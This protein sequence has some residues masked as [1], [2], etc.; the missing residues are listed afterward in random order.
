MFR[1][2]DLINNNK[3]RIPS[4]LADTIIVLVAIRCNEGSLVTCLTLT[5]RKC[6]VGD[7]QALR[8]LRSLSKDKDVMKFPKWLMRADQPALPIVIIILLSII[9]HGLTPSSFYLVLL[10][11]DWP[12]IPNSCT[13][14][15]ADLPVKS[16][17]RTLV[18]SRIVIHYRIDA[19]AGLISVIEKRIFQHTVVL[20]VI[21]R[22]VERASF[23][24]LSNN[25]SSLETGWSS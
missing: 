25:G 7:Q 1:K 16:M 19:S 22:L 11:M 3:A 2:E 10:Y 23:S 13:L 17:S 6:W 14:F 21:L 20:V 12:Q 24:N 9:I 4:L 5:L 18:S 8:A 15:V